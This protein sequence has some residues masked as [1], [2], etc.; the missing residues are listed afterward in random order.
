MPF[1]TTSTFGGRDDFQAALLK[2]DGLYQFV[3]EQG[4]FR[5]RLTQV[6]LDHLRL[7]A[8]DEQ[9]PLIGF[10]E[11]PASKILVSFP[12]GD[13]PAPA[14]GGIRP[15]KGELM[16]LGPGYRGHMR[17]QGRCRWGVIWFTAQVLAD[18]FLV[19]TERT[20]TI[21]PVAQRWRAPPAAR[22]G[23]L[24]LHAAAIRAAKVRPEAIVSAEA[25]HSTEQ[26][27]I[28]A[29]VECLSAGRA[30]QETPAAHRHQEIM[31]RF[32]DSLRVQP[33]RHMRTEELSAAI[34]VS[35]RLLQKCCQEILGMSP[36][37]YVR[38]RALYAVRRALRS[39]D[40]KATSVSRVAHSH[41][42]R[43]LGHFAGAYRSLFGELP[44]SSLRQD[45]HR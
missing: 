11:V 21:A 7:S 29:M 24:Q 31:V 43:A 22:R 10:L 15:R 44:S 40:P 28:E 26:E 30:C 23:L 6:E 14:W 42:F 2:E 35:D 9:L 32:E 5:A 18:Y 17:T 25:A 45:L 4:Q 33:S 3:T 39:R 16:I 1:S 38:L 36:T 12:I 13:Q 34:D 8:V 19:L 37:S 20:L 27:L 41:G